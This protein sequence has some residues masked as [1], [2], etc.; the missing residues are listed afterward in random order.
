VARDTIETGERVKAQ[1]QVDESLRS[2]RLSAKQAALIS[3]AVQADPAAGDK[4]L[5]RAKPGESVKVLRE[6]CDRIKAAARAEDAEA[7]H[8][9]IHAAR[10]LWTRKDRDGSA[11][12]TA[13]GTPV[14]MAEI[15]ARLEPFIQAEFERARLE[16]RREGSD[17]Y[18]FDGL[19]AMAKASSGSATG[20]SATKVPAKLFVRVDYAAFCR[21]MV[22]GDELCEID[23]FG[24][25]PV[26]VARQFAEDAFVVSLLTKGTDVVKLVHYGRQPS[27][28]QQSVVEWRSKW[29]QVLGCTRT[30]TERDHGAGW[31]NTH[32]TDV[33]DLKRFC[34]HHH[35]LK[36]Y[37]GY[38][39]VESEIPGRV[40]LV[41]PDDPDPPRRE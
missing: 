2:G 14:A 35:D 13:R 17:A 39:I 6:E 20:G 30:H 16:N 26:S 37:Q 11:V 3:D 15:K 4:L 38:R 33:N 32:E 8:R 31:A 7:A 36:T 29:C 9:R 19:V 40:L 34:D 28:L 25:V 1:P 24:P 23:G 5:A 27:A 12:M 22:E 18:A 21:G 10:A 41:P